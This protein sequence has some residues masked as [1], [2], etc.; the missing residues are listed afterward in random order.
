[1]RILL[2][3]KTGE[4]LGV[5]QRL[6]K[7]KHSVWF[8]TPP[9]CRVGDG[10]VTKPQPV[11]IATSSGKCIRSGLKALLRESQ[12]DICVVGES[13][14]SEVGDVLRE[15]R[16]ETS[17][18]GRWADT[19]QDNWEYAQKI[20]TLAG[21]ATGWVGGREW[22]QVGVGMMWDGDVHCYHT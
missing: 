18:G 21:L 5:A 16:V 13:G 15:L 8:Y 2:L 12:P 11:Q 22:Y 17:G 14:Y 4:G 6:E 19:V 1:M 9:G 10:L 20:L 7:E 3:S